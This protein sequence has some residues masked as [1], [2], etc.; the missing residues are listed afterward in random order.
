MKNSAQNPDHAATPELQGII[1][2]A[3]KKPGKR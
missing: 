1:R 3:E 2:G